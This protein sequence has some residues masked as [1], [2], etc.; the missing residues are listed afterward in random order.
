MLNLQQ[1]KIVTNHMK[2]LTQ[3]NDG[4]VKTL[5]NLFQCSKTG[6]EGISGEII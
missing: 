1:V 6:Q 2:E 3:H 5:N 4:S